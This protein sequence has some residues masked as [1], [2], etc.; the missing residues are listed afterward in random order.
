ME[1]GDSETKL[2]F[3]DHDLE[4]QDASQQEF[5]TCEMSK[6]ENVKTPLV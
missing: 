6:C 1:E 3:G 2:H 5:A 4:S